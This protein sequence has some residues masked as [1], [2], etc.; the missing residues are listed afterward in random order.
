MTAIWAGK[1][2]HFFLLRTDEGMEVTEVSEGDFFNLITYG[3][4]ELF[5]K[6]FKRDS[7]R[8]LYKALGYTSSNYSIKKTCMFIF[9]ILADIFFRILVI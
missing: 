9:L 8:G 6:Q 1:Q 5:V 2:K 7:W 4:N 3:M